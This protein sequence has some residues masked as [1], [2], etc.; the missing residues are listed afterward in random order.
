MVPPDLMKGSV[1]SKMVLEVL[2]GLQRLSPDLFQQIHF[3][4]AKLLPS[5]PS[6]LVSDE[7]VCLALQININAFQE[8]FIQVQFIVRCS[9]LL[10]L[11]VQTVDAVS[12]V[13]RLTQSRDPKISKLSERLRQKV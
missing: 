7:E 8:S 2:C 1:L 5:T 4:P 10:S 11:L 6:R 13:V 3:S 9:C 12:S